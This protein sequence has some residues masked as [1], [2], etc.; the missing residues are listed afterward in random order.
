MPFDAE[1]FLNYFGFDRIKPH[2]EDNVM[3]S[4]FQ[5]EMHTNEDRKRSFGMRKDTGIANCYVCGGWSLEQLTRDLLNRKADLEETGKFYNEYDALQ[6]LTQRGWLPEEDSIDDLKEQFAHMDG[7]EFKTID[8]DDDKYLDDSVLD[9]YKKSMHKRT[10]QRG[11]TSNAISV[12]MARFFELGYDKQTKRIIIP[13]RD[14]KSRLVGVTSRATQDEDFIRY[15]VGTIN[16]EWKL[17]MIQNTHFD[18]DKM[19]HVFDKRE[20][21]FGEHLW[22]AEDEYGNLKLRHNRVLILESPLDVVYAWSQG[23]QDHMNIG[24]IFGSKCTKE[25]MVKILRH[26][27]VVEALDNDKGGRE[28]KEHFH[29]NVENKCELYT[30]DNFGRKDLGDCTPDEVKAI[31]SRFRLHGE[32]IFAGLEVEL[33]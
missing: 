24:A 13:V 9:E 17:S 33:D 27:Y 19:L 2:D 1:E 16:P 32:D 6:F 3:A 12:E 29:K 26:H 25:Q 4:C 18:G 21:V 8:A 28:G 15:G 10:L 30:C 5:Y 22:Y 14:Y 31:A 20:Y 11:E 23:L 7:V